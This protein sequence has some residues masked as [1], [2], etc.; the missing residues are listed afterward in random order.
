MACVV[1]QCGILILA[2]GSSSRMGRPKQLLEFES[3]TLL[4]HVIKTANNSKLYPIV[5]VL[6]A[7]EELIKN[8]LQEQQ[9][10]IVTNENWQ[11]GMASSI[12]KGITFI[13]EKYPDTDGIIIAVGDQPHINTTQLHQLVEAQNTSRLPI[14]ACSYAGIIGTPALFHQSVFPELMSLKGDIGAKKIIEK[15][16]QDVVTINFDKGIIDI[17]T[18]KEYLDLLRNQKKKNNSQ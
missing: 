11:E 4:I 5:V 12:V 7:N 2:A 1:H 9:L 6:G 8:S 14:V 10:I 13:K 3:G 15:R 18:E 16:I 17:D